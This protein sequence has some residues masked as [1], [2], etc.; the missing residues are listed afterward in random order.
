MNRLYMCFEA[1]LP[2]CFVITF[3]TR[4]TYISMNRVYMSFEV[5]LL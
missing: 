2:C 3:I 4:V 5:A 1:A